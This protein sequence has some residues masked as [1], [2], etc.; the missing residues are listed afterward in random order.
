MKAWVLCAGL[1]LTVACD[2]SNSVD[3]VFKDYF[4]KYYGN[5]GDQEARDMVVNAD[6]TVLILGN[7]IRSS[8]NYRMYLVKA[9]LEGNVLWEKF[10][11]ANQESGQDIEP[12]IAGPDAGHYLIL[13]NVR[14][15]EDDS[16]AIRLTVVNTSGD[17][18]KSTYFNLLESQQGISVTPLSSGDVYVTGKTNDLG[19]NSTSDSSLPIQDTEDGLSIRFDVNYTNADT[20]VIYGSGECAIIKIFEEAG[21]FI[22]TGYSNSVT[23]G[24]SGLPTN[25]ENNFTIG[26]FNFRPDVLA[27]IRFIG[28]SGLPE[29]LKSSTNLPSGFYF[30]VGTQQVSTGSSKI[31]AAIFPKDLTGGSNI[32]EGTISNENLEAVNVSPSGGGGALIVGNE[33]TP[34]GRNIWIG[35][36][37]LD[38]GIDFSKTFGGPN[39]DDTGAAVVQLGNGDILLL[40]TME[41][42]N[43][44]KIALIKLTSQGNF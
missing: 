39:T 25:Y 35:R 5:D 28:T 15:N 11:G 40:G 22:Y 34:G 24:E 44:K 10:L 2:T 1:A 26:R 13:S 16:L 18:L 3:P 33:V 38:L 20:T 31:Y 14:K 19:S 41:L 32:I 29:L 6:G 27:P 43:Q 30:S 9:D 21:N 12:I 7:S 37:G 23:P 42:T 17:S 4:I 36:S 8:N